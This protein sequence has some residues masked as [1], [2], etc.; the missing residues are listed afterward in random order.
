MVRFPSSRSSQCPGEGGLGTVT[1]KSQ[2]CP[3]TSP[4]LKCQEARG[5]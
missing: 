5:R 4:S 2:S 1:E 3:H